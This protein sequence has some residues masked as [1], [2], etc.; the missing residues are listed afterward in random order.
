MTPE[1]KDRL[2]AFAIVAVMMI[3]LVVLLVVH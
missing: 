3:A 2:W 1:T